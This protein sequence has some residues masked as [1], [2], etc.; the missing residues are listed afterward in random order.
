MNRDTGT[1]KYEQLLERCRRLEPVLTAV[2][3]PCEES[4]LAGAIEAGE[5]GLITPIL[6]GP[7]GKIEE[8]ARKSGIDLGNTRVVDALTATLRQPRPWSWFVRGRPS[9]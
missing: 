2:A 6:V 5:K 8:V 3:H 9:S 1:G 7:A 4:A